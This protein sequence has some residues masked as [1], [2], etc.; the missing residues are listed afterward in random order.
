MF[1][2]FFVGRINIFTSLF[3]IAILTLI[4]KEVW[5]FKLSPMIVEFSPEGSGATQ[6]LIVENPDVEKVVLEMEVFE[7]HIDENGKELRKET[8]DFTIYPDSL[9]LGAKEK[10]NIRLTWIGN[11]KPNHELS[12]RFVVSQLPVNTVK[13]KK[14]NAQSDLKFL[15]QYVASLY[16]LPLEAKA[17]VELINFQLNLQHP[18]KQLEIVL[19]NKGTAHQIL[20]GASLQLNGKDT[21]GKNVSL[22]IPAKSLKIFDAENLLALSKRKFKI[23]L[24]SHFPLNKLEKAKIQFAQ[25]E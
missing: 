10:R 12:F 20:T 24:E 1:G 25:P 16:V 4:H 23:P 6:T 5:A 3:F 9:E 22:E 2:Q 18:S 21:Q 14:E 19:Q 13:P 15:L 7:R 11:K 8:A 17:E